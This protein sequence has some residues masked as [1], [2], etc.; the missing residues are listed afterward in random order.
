[1]ISGR[2]ASIE[3]S[4]EAKRSIKSYACDRTQVDGRVGKNE[5]ISGRVA[6]FEGSDEAARG[7]ESC[8]VIGH[9]E[10]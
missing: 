1:M 10:A 7:I 4:S 9:K 3:G 8:V 2:A 6:S 5:F